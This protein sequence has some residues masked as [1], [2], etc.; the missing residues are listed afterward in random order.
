MTSLSVESPAR[1]A[2]ACD[3]VSVRFGGQVA[4]QEVGFE[5]AAGG[6]LGVVGPNGAGKTTLL[7]V[8]SGLVRPQAGTVHAFGH[9]LLSLHPSKLRSVVGLSR[10]FQ[11]ADQCGRLTILEYM[12]LGLHNQFRTS[13]TS[14]T[15]GLPGAR[16]E[17]QAAV[18]AVVDALVVNGL[19]H[20]EL[21]TELRELPYGTRKRIDVAR[22]WVG[23]PRLVLLD[24]PTSGLSDGEAAETVEVLKGLIGQRDCA[25]LIVDHRVGFV[26]DMCPVVLVLDFGQI[27]AY[28]ECGE[29]FQSGEVRRAYLGHD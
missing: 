5:L 26:R 2:I 10:A 4:L 9:D 23:D 11:L 15:F 16:Y 19:G 17:E 6:V 1:V 18:A 25:V 8:L 20:L 27:I 7:N 13:L 29:V 3:G 21:T 12:L 22:A 24:E 28:G 14:I